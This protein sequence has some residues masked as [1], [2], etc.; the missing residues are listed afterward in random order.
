MKSRI[1]N[2]KQVG[3]KELR[4]HS[5]S[6]LLVNSNGHTSNPITGTKN[7]YIT[8]V[9]AD[10]K[11]WLVH[12]L[13]AECFIPNPENKPV[14]NHIDG[15]KANPR[16]ENLEW[17]THRENALH[18]YRRGLKH[19]VPR[20]KFTRRQILYIRRSLSKF[21]HLAKKYGVSYRVIYNIH[22]LLTHKNIK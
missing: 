8:V 6:G 12:R 17:A 22:Y 16:L 10:K 1:A 21:D 14:V 3:G 5:E 19:Y 7:G 18:A 9:G 15:N 20:K 11:V 2:K 13:V 4:L